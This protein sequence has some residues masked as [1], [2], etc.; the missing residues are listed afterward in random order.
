MKVQRSSLP[1]P[2][3]HESS[4][5]R[6]QR[7]LDRSTCRWYR[8]FLHTVLDAD[9]LIPIPAL[10]PAAGFED[11]TDSDRASF[12]DSRFIR[13]LSKRELIQQGVANARQTSVTDTCDRFVRSMRI[14]RESYPIRGMLNSENHD[15]NSFDASHTRKNQTGMSFPPSSATT[16]H[17]PMN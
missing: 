17:R 10:I 1:Q 11:P 2:A 15:G 14:L 5:T 9:F 13:R 7:G 12:A 8:Q 4:P 16:I 3:I 6:R